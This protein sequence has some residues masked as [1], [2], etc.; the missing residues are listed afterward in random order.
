[1]YQNQVFKDMQKNV[2]VILT[3]TFINQMKNIKFVNN[4]TRR[5]SAIFDDYR[6]Q[7]FWFEQERS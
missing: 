3:I 5:A 2:G 6:E 4:G 1:M 7:V